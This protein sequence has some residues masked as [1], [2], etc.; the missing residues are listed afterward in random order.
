[1]HFERNPAEALI[2]ALKEKDKGNTDLAQ[3]AR[4]HLKPAAA[5]RLAPLLTQL[6]AAEGEA[7]APVMEALNKAIAE[8]DRTA[9]DFI[10]DE[11]HGQGMPYSD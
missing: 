4:Q 1:M 7:L 9:T 8:I 3:L 6:S 5:D 11:N 10:E 2:K